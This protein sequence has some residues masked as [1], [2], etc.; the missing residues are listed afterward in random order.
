M[1]GQSIQAAVNTAAPGST[2]TVEP[3]VY[4]ESAG[5]PIAVIVTKNDIQLV[6]NNTGTGNCWANNAGV[7]G[8]PPS[9]KSLDGRPLT[10]CS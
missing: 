3:G 9:Q 5:Q 1:P 8:T 6:G 2:I 10:A 4:H 7:N